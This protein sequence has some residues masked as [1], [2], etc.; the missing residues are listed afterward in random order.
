MKTILEKQ[1]GVPPP[2]GHS[3]W[4]VGGSGARLLG[5]LAPRRPNSV[6][7]W[8]SLPHRLCLYVPN[9]YCG[10]EISYRVSVVCSGRPVG[11]SYTTYRKSKMLRKFRNG[12]WAY[13]L[14]SGWRWVGTV[15][16]AA[17]TCGGVPVQWKGTGDF[18]CGFPFKGR[19]FF[20]L[21]IVQEGFNLC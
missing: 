6:V 21:A 13:C 20:C 7:Y 10:W 4:E 8:N 19:L 15:N 14:W 5:L 9:S 3:P 18:K 16:P 17:Y 2:G 12:H 11:V 1:Q